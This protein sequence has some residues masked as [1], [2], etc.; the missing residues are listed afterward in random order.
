MLEFKTIRQVAAL[1]ILPENRL[2]Q[3]R[4]QKLLPGI[5]SGNRFLVN[6]DALVELLNRESGKAVA[7]NE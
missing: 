7:I 1:G 2:R 3:M 4:K 5:Q 6:V